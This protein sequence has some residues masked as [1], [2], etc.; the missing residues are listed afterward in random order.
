MKGKGD[1]RDIWAPILIILATVLIT[2]IGIAMN[3]Q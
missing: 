1:S 2:V 3:G